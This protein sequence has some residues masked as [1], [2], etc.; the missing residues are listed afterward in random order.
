MGDIS[1]RGAPVPGRENACILC[2]KAG[3][4]HI[5]MF[6]REIHEPWLYYLPIV[7]EVLLC[8]YL[9]PVF[10]YLNGPVWQKYLTC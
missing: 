4:L 6:E 3:F 10:R 7:N 5:C 8:I 2:Y 9:L 1:Y